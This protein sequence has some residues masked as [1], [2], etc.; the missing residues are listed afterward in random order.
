MEKVTKVM[1]EQGRRISI[2]KIL[3]DLIG[4]DED[5]AKVYDKIQGMNIDDVIKAEKAKITS[6]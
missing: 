1:D 2:F 3:M 6:R 5:R 4:I